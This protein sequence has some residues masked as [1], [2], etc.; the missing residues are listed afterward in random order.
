MYKRERIIRAVYLRAEAIFF[1]VAIYFQVL[2]RTVFDKNKKSTR[3]S[4]LLEMLNVALL[5]P[6]ASASTPSTNRPGLVSSD[7]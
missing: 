6:P 4:K 2:C 5:L 7:S 3:F 1:E